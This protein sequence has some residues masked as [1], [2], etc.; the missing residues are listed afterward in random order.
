MRYCQDSWEEP[1]SASLTELFAVIYHFPKLSSSETLILQN[2]HSPKLPFSEI[3]I[4]PETPIFLFLRNSHFPIS[5]NSLFLRKHLF[6][7]TPI[8]LF[9]RNSYSSI[10][11]NHNSPKTPISP[12]LSFS[13][14]PILYITLFPLIIF[15]SSF[16]CYYGSTS[17][18]L[19][20]FSY[21][22]LLSIHWSRLLFPHANLV[23]DFRCQV[24][25]LLT[26]PFVY[27]GL[28]HLRKYARVLFSTFIHSLFLHI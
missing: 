20:P 13:E 4:S 5:P 21:Y 25:L 18:Y 26:D 23:T 27:G 11:R 15:W 14:I 7:E 2:P 17:C 22:L 12:K 10:L 28:P 1:G 8:F 16:P 9:L 3:S 19:G 6:S 24:S